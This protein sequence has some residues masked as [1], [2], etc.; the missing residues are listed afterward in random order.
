MSFPK[1]MAKIV[2]TAI[3]A[4]EDTRSVWESYVQ[5]PDIRKRDF[6]VLTA[7]CGGGGG[8]QIPDT[9]AG[10]LFNSL[11]YQNGHVDALRMVLSMSG[12]IADVEPPGRWLVVDFGA[13]PGTGFLAVAALFRHS[14]GMPVS[15]SYVHIEPLKAMGWLALELFD[16][17]DDIKEG[18]F[19]RVQDLSAVTAAMHRVWLDGCD[20]VLFVFSYVLCQPGVTEATVAS[21]AR[22]MRSISRVAGAMGC[23]VVM[24]DANLSRTRYPSLKHRLAGEAMLALPDPMVC[25]H[26]VTYL[27]IDGS[28][29]DRRPA[30]DNLLY[31]FG[32]LK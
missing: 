20:H 13:G 6:R 21:F 10:V 22:L 3:L 32:R 2:G 24:T 1:L 12:S 30:T 11:L 8:N 16:G 18:L 4:E 29:R 31:A 27:N 14:Y 5:E 19:H 26:A 25:S 15:L 17:C 23:H 28:V 9:P 7:A